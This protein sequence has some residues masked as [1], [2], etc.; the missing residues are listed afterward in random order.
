MPYKLKTNSA[1]GP[2]QRLR[3]GS[4]NA[5]RGQQETS[6][7]G[8][9]ATA[10]SQ[11]SQKQYNQSVSKGQCD[12]HEITKKKAITSN[13][14]SLFS[15]RLLSNGSTSQ[16]FSCDKYQA[17]IHKQQPSNLPP[18]VFSTMPQSTMEDWP[19]LHVRMVT[20][21]IHSMCGSS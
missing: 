4:F 3:T 14:I 8:A 2:V 10:P 18:P 13:C 21:Q 12:F 17:P 1:R 15:R 7:L 6:I 11:E 20:L 5:A 9:P 16:L 19:T